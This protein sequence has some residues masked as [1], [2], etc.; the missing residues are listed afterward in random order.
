MTQLGNHALLESRMLAMLCSRACPGSIIVQ[1]LDLIRALRE[2]PWTIVSGFQSPTEQECL[3]NL[4]RGER[5]VIVCP[6][7]SA[8]GLRIPSAWE[9][10]IATGRMLVMSPFE[11]TVR[12]ATA[13]TAEQRNQF[14][15]SLADAV[16][17][18]HAAPGGSLDR[19]I[20]DQ[21]LGR[22]PL[23]TLHDSANA[24]LVN[25]GA[26][27]VRAD[28]VNIMAAVGSFKAH[29]ASVPNG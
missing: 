25:L 18:P 10:A 26:R 1:T 17:I 12:R 15:V 4:L 22:K 14:V 28:S 8:E 11:N 9:S 19:L 3:E 29:A 27:P 20:R 2:T 21:I 6:A 16:L 7:R 23:W 5:P 24:H 13:A